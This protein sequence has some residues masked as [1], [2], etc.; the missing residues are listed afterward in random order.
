M[1]EF[2][3]STSNK[4]SSFGRDSDRSRGRSGGDSDRPRYRD[5]GR[6]R[7]GPKRFDRRDSNREMTDVICD[8]CKK[9]CQVPF[10]PTS[11]KPIYCSDCFKKNPS[12]GS[13]S[14]ELVEIN[15]KLDKI[16]KALSID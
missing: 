1:A 2:R 11:D 5:S 9:P 3:R 4:R 14:G 13:K 15:R 7:D 8:S 10:K 12:S 6:G 16:L